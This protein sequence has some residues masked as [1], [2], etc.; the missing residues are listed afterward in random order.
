MSTVIENLL[1]R[2]QKLVEQLEEAPSV[3][4]R[5]RIEHQLEQINTALDFLDRPGPREG[6]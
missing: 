6:R 4:D 2:K 3:E 1:L 5:D